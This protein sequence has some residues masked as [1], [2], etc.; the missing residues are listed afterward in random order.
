MA[1]NKTKEKIEEITDEKKRAT[2][3]ANKREAFDGMRAY[4]QSEIAHKKDAID[5]IKAILATTVVIFIGLVSAVFSAV[6]LTL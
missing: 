4:H 3:E 1:E 5:I 6:R 2:H